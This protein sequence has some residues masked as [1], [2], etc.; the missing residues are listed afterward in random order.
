MEAST[1]LVDWDFLGPA[2]NDNGNVQFTDLQATN[3]AL[4][5][6]RAMRSP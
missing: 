3:Y 2:L 4:R 1:N 5:F 6:Y